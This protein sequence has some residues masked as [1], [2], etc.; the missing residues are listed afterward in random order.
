MVE[1]EKC[2]LIVAANK[3]LVLCAIPPRPTGGSCGEARSGIGG[4]YHGVSRSLRRQRRAAILLLPEVNLIS[5]LPCSANPR[6]R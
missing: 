2:I 4:R 6:P 1:T 5:C 3:F